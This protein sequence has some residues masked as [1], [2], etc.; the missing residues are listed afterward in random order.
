MPPKARASTLYQPIVKVVRLPLL[1]I[2]QVL[3]SNLSITIGRPDGWFYLFLLVHQSPGA[4]EG[5]VS[6]TMLFDISLA[7]NVT[8]YDAL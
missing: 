1:R 8:E 7:M 3:S 4:V 5:S 6:H 2:R